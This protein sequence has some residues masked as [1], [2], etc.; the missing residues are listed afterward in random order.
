MFPWQHVCCPKSGF[1][2]FSVVNRG[3]V[4]SIPSRK[5]NHDTE[6]RSCLVSAR[7]SRNRQRDHSRTRLQASDRRPSRPLA[8]DFHIHRNAGHLSYGYRAE[9]GH[10]I[11]PAGMDHRN[12]MV[13][14]DRLLR[15]RIRSLY[16]ATSVGNAFARLQSPRWEIVGACACGNVCGTA[17]RLSLAIPATG[18]FN[19]IPGTFSMAISLTNSSLQD[20]L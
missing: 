4:Y 17:G 19:V 18:I 2:S 11:F 10:R 20:K 5:S 16:Y 15:I 12:D 9:M 6:V 13:M 7:D 14:Y 1:C 8:F 3:D